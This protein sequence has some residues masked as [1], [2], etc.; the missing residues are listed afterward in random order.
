MASSSGVETDEVKRS[1]E[2]IDKIIPLD[3]R[4]I[5]AKECPDAYKDL[6]PAEWA[7]KIYVP[8]LTS[9]SAKHV[10]SWLDQCSVRMQGFRLTKE[11]FLSIILKD[12]R[13]MKIRHDILKAMK[14][15]NVRTLEDVGDVILERFSKDTDV[16]EMLYDVLSP[17]K[18][19]TCAEAE[20]EVER[21][22][23]AYAYCCIRQK[24]VSY[25]NE[26]DIN[27]I[28]IRKLP[29]HVQLAVSSLED[30]NKYTFRDLA[31]KCYELESSEKVI[32]EGKRNMA[33]HRCGER[34]HFKKDCPNSK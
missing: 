25:L 5:F 1:L 28:F 6:P 19:K 34:G 2:P 29:N 33:C 31:D 15:E 30:L 14:D 20:Q 26:Q 13:F 21:V 16:V 3:G 12:T 17:E 27:W 32:S 18:F 9:R 7:M 10:E 4:I 8:D 22:L 24:R 11:C 23:Q